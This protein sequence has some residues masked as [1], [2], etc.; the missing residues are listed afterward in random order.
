MTK[1]PNLI[2]RAACLLSGVLALG[3]CQKEY[4]DPGKYKELIEQSFPVD[5]P[6]PNHTWTTVH[7]VNINLN[8][9]SV[10]AYDVYVLTANPETDS[11]ARRLHHA[12]LSGS[13]RQSLKVCCP[14]QTRALWVVAIDSRG[15]AI[16]MGQSVGASTEQLTMNMG[17]GANVPLSKDELRAFG[18]QDYTYCFEENFPATG[19]WDF[20]DL[21]MG[22]ELDRTYGNGGTQPDTLIITT[23]LRAV[24]SMS[25]IAAA[26]RLRG[27]T[28]TQVEPKY[29]SDNAY[30]YYRYGGDIVPSNK[31]RQLGVKIEETSDEYRDVYVP[32]FNDAHY[33]ISRSED[34]TGAAVRIYYNTRTAEDLANDPVGKVSGLTVPPVVAEYRILFRPQYRDVL[35]SFNLTD[36]DLF[37]VTN[38]NGGYF[39]THTV[40]YKIS[41]VI[42]KYISGL[43]YESYN[44]NYP[45]ALL[46]A[47]EF[48][49][50]KEGTAVGSLHENIYGGAYQMPNHGFADWAQ[51]RTSARDWYLYPDEAGI[52]K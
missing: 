36:L 26:M 46:L 12:M 51:Q 23:R 5:N 45:W 38:Y 30:E 20:N 37:I 25:S 39:E 28:L 4:F 18:E 35:N 31:D 11:S 50:P 43:S 14:L 8:M 44:K 49:Y 1:H 47:S 42:Y 41:E 9:L 10:D 13:I 32:L 16:C 17:E 27:V 52:Y 24:G 48:Q 6:D 2:Y 29:V 15:Q 7:E 34:N 33:A 22:V 19:D 21:V 3:A 40:P